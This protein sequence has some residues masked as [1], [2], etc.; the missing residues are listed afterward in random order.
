MRGLTLP[1]LA[2]AARVDTAGADEAT[3]AGLGV[4]NGTGDGAADGELSDEGF[5]VIGPG[6]LATPDSAAGTASTATG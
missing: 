3:A 2:A 5:A 6:A 4:D 1:G